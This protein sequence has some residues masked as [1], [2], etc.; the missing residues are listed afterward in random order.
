MTT[1]SPTSRGPARRADAERNR[2][3][4]LEAARIA[5]ADP[6]AD[7]SMAEVA[8]RSGVGS[9]TLYRNFATR[10][11]LLGALYV[12][13]VDAVCEAAATAEGDTPGARFA[14]WLHRFFVYFT[15]KRHVASE[16]LEH[17]DPG[18]PVF[19]ASRDR[20]LA[21]GRPLLRAAQDARE[22]DADLTLEQALDLVVAVGKIRGD[23]AYVEPILRAA[24]AG[25]RQPPS[26]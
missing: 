11:E 9:A 8:R 17:A 22:V 3:K 20:V 15:S 14:T 5:F 23:R 24:L 2:A 4:I 1:P 6:A 21:A 18:S 13:E 26:R 16:L 12:D 19:G 10:R 7:V 25:L